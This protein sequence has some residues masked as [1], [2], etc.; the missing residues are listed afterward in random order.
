MSKLDPALA[1]VIGALIAAL[2]TAWFNRRSASES[3]EVEAK[4]T[5]VAEFKETIAAMKT[6]QD[7]MQAL[8][9]KQD[10]QIAKQSARIDVLE[11]DLS[12]TNQDLSAT[13][14]ELTTVKVA[15][16][17]EQ[18]AHANARGLFR[19]ATRHIK[20]FHAWYAAWAEG[21]RAG[22]DEPPAVPEPLTEWL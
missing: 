9:N 22:D 13:N 12:T 19:V 17:D 1:A 6:V 2:V 10:S 5:A 20:D 14:Q 15:L 16:V 21:D 18:R 3:N 11:Q 7:A 8:Q 4:A